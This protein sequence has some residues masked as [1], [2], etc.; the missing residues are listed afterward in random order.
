MYNFQFNHNFGDILWTF[1]ILTDFNMIAWWTQQCCMVISKRNGNVNGDLSVH[2]KTWLRQIIWMNHWWASKNFT[3]LWH[4]ATIIFVLSFPCLPPTNSMS[5]AMHFYKYYEWI[6]HGVIMVDMGA[7][8]PNGPF[9]ITQINKS[10]KYLC[11][12]VKMHKYDVDEFCD[13]PDS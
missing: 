12:Y 11:L 7:F 2:V 10:S 3:F 9:V 8:H 5:Q 1:I 4:E 6:F 13:E